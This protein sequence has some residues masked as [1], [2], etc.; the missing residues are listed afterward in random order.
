M[1]ARPTILSLLAAL[2]V[3]SN[4][5]CGQQ[6]M[7][8]IRVTEL[9]EKKPQIKVT[10]ISEK[11]FGTKLKQVSFSTSIVTPKYTE[12][13]QAEIAMGMVVIVKL[14]DEKGNVLVQQK[15]S[16]RDSKWNLVLDKGDGNYVVQIESRHFE[17]TDD[18][19]LPSLW[20]TEIVLD[21]IPPEPVLRTFVTDNIET[22]ESILSLEAR[23]MNEKRGQVD[24]SEI[25]LDAGESGEPQK[26]KLNFVGEEEVP[27]GGVAQVF[28]ADPT[29]LSGSVAVAQ[30]AKAKC[31]D[32]GG[33]EVVTVEPIQAKDH[34]IRLAATSS[35]KSG[36]AVNDL[37]AGSKEF[38]FV[39]SSAF[40][41]KTSVIFADNGQKLS[42]DLLERAQKNLRLYLTKSEPK[43]VAD[44]KTE[45]IV[46][47]KGYSDENV[48]NFPAN[49]EGPLHFYLS[50][51]KV[52]PVTKEQ[53]WV[54]SVPFDLY[55][56]RIG[57]KIKWIEKSK[58]E[59]V[60]AKKNEKI[61]FKISLENAGAPLVNSDFILEESQD[62][63]NWSVP[64]KFTR[65]A[66]A[67]TTGASG[68]EFEY[69]VEYPFD[70]EKPYRLRLRT[71][72]IAGNKFISE[73]SPNLVVRKDVA[74]PGTNGNRSCK[75][76]L[77]GKDE[78]GSKLSAVLVSKL[79]CRKAL[80]NGQL[81]DGWNAT[82]RFENL[83]GAML[84]LSDDSNRSL[85][86]KVVK[87]GV[88]TGIFSRIHD[89]GL[90]VE[91]SSAPTTEELEKSSVQLLS[92]TESILDIG[93]D[94][95][96]GDDVKL[97]LDSEVTGALTTLNACYGKNESRPELK[98][99]ESGQKLM[100]SPFPCN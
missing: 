73:L 74:A 96:A 69:T 59:K 14:M 71:E 35:G 29:R 20:S 95:V 56:D 32:I 70:D 57:P 27:G 88:E 23:V 55:I 60:K 1:R 77:S 64:E 49:W 54:N 86:F 89:T 10:G 76:Q 82:V 21:S 75:A 68:A 4:S 15:Q 66:I 43:S 7:H 61:K 87:N 33:N 100:L 46:W 51:T 37:A 78:V 22:G 26:I 39:D 72:D 41:F 5:G 11:S 34:G 98:I 80:P 45:D 50:M 42:G 30:S 90:D 25:E 38:L 85:G 99:Q 52:D 8:G 79:L 16:G 92:I 40:V 53:V 44:I 47:S 28:R 62:N 97:I 58:I 9:P 12:A 67:Q 18:D 94:S 3:L 93:E 91:K 19:A 6:K 31:R 81:T 63:K 24:C 2:T 13:V 65:V 36:Q 17:P 48:V 83:G 84:R